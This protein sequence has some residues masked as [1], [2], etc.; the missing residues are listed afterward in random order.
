MANSAEQI[1]CSTGWNTLNKISCNT[2]AMA[3]G[4]NKDTCTELIQ[5][6]MSLSTT[7]NY[8]NIIQ[9]AGHYKGNGFVNYLYL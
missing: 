7:E 2:T 6:K 9:T 5:Y 3:A 4:D 8:M 1:V